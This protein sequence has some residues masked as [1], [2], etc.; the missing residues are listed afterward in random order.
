M[1]A[2]PPRLEAGAVRAALGLPTALVRTFAGRPLLRDGQMLDPETQWL[3]RVQRLTR[4]PDVAT[5]P[6][7]QGRRALLRQSRLTGGD[8]PIGETRDVE[9]PTAAGPMRARLYVPT[10]AAEEAG[11]L[12]VF[13][14]GGGMVYGD[15]ESHDAVCRFLAERAGVRV[16]ALDYRLAP[17]HRY[18]AAVDDAW[19]GFQWAV[20]HADDLGADPARVAVGGDSAGG[21]LSAVVA[22]KAAQAGVPCAFQLL[23]Y[24][25][26]DFLEISQSRVT[27]SDGF[28]LTK[29]FRD[30]AEESYLS[31]NDDRQDPNV[32]PLRLEKVPEGLAPAHIVTAG[33]DP[34]RDEGEAYARLL[35][36]AGVTVELKRYP[37]MIHGFFNIVGVGRS[38]RAAVA[39]VAAKLKAALDASA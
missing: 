36:E 11:P 5:L 27:F 2:L 8:Q 7:E 32:S 39:E 20:E 1:P 26:T 16:L 25:A 4:E 35:A 31:P 30:L 28:Y 21:L 24:P 6:I 33:F 18:P 12:L 15:L 14:H 10:S 9:V 13:L 22:V 3:L 17:E 23:V 37:G 38:N 19:A 29:A 34:L